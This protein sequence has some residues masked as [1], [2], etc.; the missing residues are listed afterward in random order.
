MLTKFNNFKDVNGFIS[1]TIH[2]YI[3]DG[4]NIDMKES[5]INKEK[6]GDCTFKTVLKR[7]V[8]GIECKV[9]ITLHEKDTVHG[10]S[11]TFHK[12]DSVGD[13][14]WGEE[15]RTFESSYNVFTSKDDHVCKNDNSKNTH[16]KKFYV[17]DTHSTKPKQDTK[18]DDH[19][20][21]WVTE[22]CDRIKRILMKNGCD[23]SWISKYTVPQTKQVEHKCDNCTHKHETNST[24]DDYDEDS[25]VKLI[26]Y[27][28]GR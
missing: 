28:F 1:D 12:V 6:D 8:D 3:K 20:V 9:L 5:A 18:Q 16:N 25:L 2:S 17:K 10:K 24:E 23:C 14:K 21:A 11:F 13:T 15:T 7:D 26:R 19:D 22:N 27:L 4:Y